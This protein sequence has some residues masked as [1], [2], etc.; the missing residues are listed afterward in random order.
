VLPV[1]WR[2]AASDEFD[3]IIDHIAQFDEAAADR[4]EAAGLACA[5]R[6]SE[7]PYLYRPGRVAGTREAVI[8]PNYILIYRVGAAQVEILS[9]VH[10]RR[11]YPP[12][13]QPSP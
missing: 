13:S 1:L 3:R 7:H 10:S 2:E 8:H 6:L 9:V 5:E 4:L 12:E 11:Q